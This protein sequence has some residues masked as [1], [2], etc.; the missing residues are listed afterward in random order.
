MP[1]PTHD[2]YI[3][4]I[5]NQSPCNKTFTIDE[6]GDVTKSS[7]GI[8]GAVAQ[9][10]H[11]PSLADLRELLLSVSENENQVIVCGYIPATIGKGTYPLYTMKT[12]TD[13]WNTI[14]GGM[15]DGHPVYARVKYSGAAKEDLR[16]KHSTFNP[17]S[18][19]MMDYDLPKTQGT[20]IT[21]GS[22]DEVDA[23]LRCR[24]NQL[25]VGFLRL[26]SNSGRVHINGEAYG[27]DGTQAFACHYY[28]KMANGANLTQVAAVFRDSKAIGD[29]F[30]YP[31]ERVHNDVARV[32]LTSSFDYSVL[33][34]ERVSYEGKPTLVIA[35]GFS[36]WGEAEVT[37]AVIHLQDGAYFTIDSLNKAIRNEWVGGS[38][39]GWFDNVL[40]EL[41]EHLSTTERFDEHGKAQVGGKYGTLPRDTLF[42]TLDGRF[43]TFADAEKEIGNA[44]WRVQS[45][46]RESTSFAAFINKSNKSQRMV[47]YDTLDLVYFIASDLTEDIISEGYNDEDISAD[48]E[49]D[50]TDADVDESI[51][52]GYQS[53]LGND[54]IAVELAEMIH[55][56]ANIDVLKRKVAGLIARAEVDDVNR[57]TLIVYM[58]ERIHA[59]TDVR[60]SKESVKKMCSPG[61][62]ELADRGQPDW[63]KRYVKLAISNMYVDI[64]ERRYMHI[65]G[66]NTK[67]TC[68][69]PMNENGVRV[70]AQTY[71]DQNGYTEVVNEVIYDPRNVDVIVDDKRH[72]KSLNIYNH[73]A[74]PPDV[75]ER[76][77]IVEHLMKRHINMV[78]GDRDA[79]FIDWM[80]WQVQFPG[81]VLGWLPLI[82]SC[83]G[84]GKTTI[85]SMVAAALGERNVK[86]VT[87]NSIS[88]RFNTWATGCSL[89]IMEEIKLEGENR[90]AVVNSL[91]SYITNSTVEIEGKGKD[92]IT[93]D[94][95]TNLLCFTNHKDAIAFT[96]TDR[97]WWVMFSKIESEEHLE[98]YIKENFDVTKHEYFSRL[99]H[100]IG[101]GAKYIRKWLVEHEISQ[102]FLESRTA[103]MTLEKELMMST[104]EGDHPE[105]EMIDRIIETATDPLITPTVIGQSALNNAAAISGFEVS[106]NRSMKGLVRVAMKSRGWQLISPIKYK[107][108]VLRFWIKHTMTNDEIR[109]VLDKRAPNIKLVEKD[110][111]EEN[112]DDVD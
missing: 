82:Q 8:T 37:D 99:I 16:P 46:T 84:V 53:A 41:T 42:E 61:M 81:Q 24:L 10:V 55:R 70:T 60:P 76:N 109:K 18:Y 12:I 22:F 112:D 31:V 83:Q 15:R 27:S 91:K 100:A 4:V 97:R 59:L 2:D 75:D 30:T 98:W 57:N 13:T 110:T 54:N 87:N 72:G 19:M 39:S 45:V 25:D 5:T 78:I 92:A 51:R 26:S 56:A 23:A 9:T 66:F 62:R 79:F 33:S 106:H 50:W 47:Y 38:G 77:D 3:T 20:G 104:Q 103:P 89:G 65:G 36:D 68:L 58:V 63:T 35:D 93:V 40:P 1:H 90:Y 96:E 67:Y 52:Q 48:G 88:G 95:V 28:I 74:L 111:S 6:N 105:R 14:P 34:G 29:R 86:V 73:D 11:V 85:G 49:S 101:N 64:A 94:N 71:C 80:A 44:K 69:V 17:S 108:E 102:E 21:Y 32:Y 107:G 43:I 7:G